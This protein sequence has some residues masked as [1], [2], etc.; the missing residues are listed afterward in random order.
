M[1]SLSVAHR[2]LMEIF[3]NILMC[4]T[5]ISLRLN[6][7]AIICFAERVKYDDKLLIECKCENLIINNIGPFYL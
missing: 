6:K 1:C 7:Y 5:F 2:V 3:N 4:F